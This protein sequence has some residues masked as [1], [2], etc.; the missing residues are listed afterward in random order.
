MVLMCSWETFMAS[1]STRTWFPFLCKSKSR[2]P[3]TPRQHFFVV[4]ARYMADMHVFLVAY[5]GLVDGGPAG[6]IW[7]NLVCWM[8]FLL[9]NV[10]MA[11]MAS[12]YVPQVLWMMMSLLIPFGTDVFNV[13][14]G[15]NVWRPVSLG[16]RTI[17]AQMPEVSELPYGMALC[18]GLAS[19]GSLRCIFLRDW[20]SSRTPRC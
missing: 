6:V 5:F 7:M 14:K 18:L 9:V 19:N 11:E 17:T 3:T 16:L 15:S 10:S 4:K 13:H 20:N 12:M 1:K 8:G 2:V